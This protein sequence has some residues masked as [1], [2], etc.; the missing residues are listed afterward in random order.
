MPRCKQ[1]PSYRLHKQSGQAVVTLPDGLGGRRDVLLGKYDTPESRQEYRRV[2][3]EWETAGRRLPP[4]PAAPQQSGLTIN[5]LLLAY[6]RFAESYYVKDG[7]PT[8]EVAAIRA[9]LRF[10]KRLYGH[11]PVAEFS[12]RCLKAVRQAMIEHPITVRVK[13]KT[14]DPETGE[15]R[16]EEREKVLRNGLAR[17]CV[18]KQIGRIK[19]LF[20]W[21]VEEE[22][23]PV[24]VHQALPCVPGLKKDKGSAREKPRVKPVP[25]AFVEAVLPLVPP[26]VRTMIE[27]QRL[28]GGRPQD[29]V[30]MRAIDI[31]MTGPVWEYRPRRYK[32]EHHNDDNSPDRERV[33]FLGPKAQALIKPYLTLNVTDYLF[34]PARSEQARGAER[35]ERRRTPMTA[36][37]AGRK[38]AANRRAPPGDHYDVGSY[39]KAI[40][41]ACLKAN[42]PVWFPLQ[43]RHSRGTEIRK[44]FGL[45][46]SQAVLGHTELGVTQVYAEVDRDTARRVMG[47][48]G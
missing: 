16:V 31:D 20:A 10:V 41:R 3:L 30:G 11:T 17:K 21:G 9:A 4:K 42:V 28:C 34:S 36:S 44:R 46:A 6:Y 27:V 2:L 33:V 35:R 40:R 47:E 37:Q 39:R 12:P 14:V 48:I 29:I 7:K 32:T 26:T 8:S 18:N 1:D 15:E 5:E 45:E 38:P 25:E 43:L 19:R 13:V 24:A 22:L 23:V